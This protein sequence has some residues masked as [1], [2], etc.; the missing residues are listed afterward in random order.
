MRRAALIAVA[1][2]V[3]APATPAKGVKP[4][5]RLTSTKPLVVRG[6]HFL[7]REKV[8]VIARGD[9]LRV[10]HVAAAADGTFRTVFTAVKVS[11]CHGLDVQA[12]GSR[13]SR[14]DY[15]IEMP[16]CA[17]LAE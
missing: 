9:V 10:H 2:L 17:D 14:A 7:P 16:D 5:L 15:A 13:G 8:K 1:A 4:S 6:A 3:L 11:S 12:L